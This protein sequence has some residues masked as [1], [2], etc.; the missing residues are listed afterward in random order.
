MNSVAVVFG[1]WDNRSSELGLS[2]IDARK[3]IASLHGAKWVETTLQLQ[4]LLQAGRMQQLL[5]FVTGDKLE[6]TFAT[7]QYMVTTYK[8]SLTVFVSTDIEYEKARE[9]GMQTILVT[10]EYLNHLKQ[11]EQRLS[12]E[13]RNIPAVCGNLTKK[14]IELKVEKSKTKAADK[15]KPGVAV[16]KG[17]PGIAVGRGKPGEPKEGETSTVLQVSLVYSDEYQSVL[18]RLNAGGVTNFVTMQSVRLSLGN[19]L[20]SRELK[21]QT[22]T[23]PKPLEKKQNAEKKKVEKHIMAPVEKK[24]KVDDKTTEY[25]VKEGDATINQRKVLKTAV[26][27][28]GQVISKGRA[29]AAAETAKR[30]QAIRETQQA[31]DLAVPE[32]QIV[33]PSIAVISNR[34]SALSGRIS[35]IGAAKDDGKISLTKASL[36]VSTAN[37]EDVKELKEAQLVFAADRNR[38]NQK[39]FGSAVEYLLNKNKVTEAQIAAIREMIDVAKR[40]KG[41]VLT[42]EDALILTDT[43]DERSVL[44]AMTSVFGVRFMGTE[45]M[46]KIPIITSVFPKTVCTKYKF[47]HIEENPRKLIACEGNMLESYL[48]Q[49]FGNASVVYSL[50]SCILKRLSAEKEWEHAGGDLSN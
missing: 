11:F 14:E 46:M 24:K 15:V 16:G 3:R 32:G 36:S 31:A 48:G 41:I 23:K 35:K 37:Q 21:V 47:I 8:C 27:G 22:L 1:N 20:K 30:K 9:Q 4:S 40:E 34:M 26:E 6:N 49:N 2:A 7:I 33:L 38:F 29:E 19:R 43:I 44:K 39:I 25:L 42:I 10:K 17:K 13:K 50:S 18:R 28:K 12:I 5:A 45:E